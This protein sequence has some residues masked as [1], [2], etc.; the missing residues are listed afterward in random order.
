MSQSVE[1]ALSGD[2]GMEVASVRLQGSNYA[3]AA[4]SGELCGLL[5]SRDDVLGGFLDELDDFAG[6]LAFE[7]N[8][9]FASGQ[10]LRGYDTVTSTSYVTDAGVPL[11]QAGLAFTPVNG[12]FQILVYDKENETT[13]TTNVQVH[14]LGDDTDTTLQDLADAINRIDSLEASVTSDGRLTIT[15]QSADHQFAF[16]DDTSGLLA[17]IGI[18][19]LFTGS[20]AL[21]LGINEAM[22]SDP[23]KFAA[24][25]GGI[26]ADTR[27]AVA[28]AQ[29]AD[30]PIASHHDESI[31][32]VYDRLVAGMTQSS[33]AAQAAADGARAFQET[34]SG[35]KLAIS[36]VSV[37]EE[38][39]NLLTFQKAFQA[40]ARYI[41]VLNDIFD[42]LVNL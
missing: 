28:L 34:L 14:L 1:V 37:D 21:G 42:L 5:V 20:T 8:K 15:S 41:S 11:D 19:T 17:A 32:T 30:E 40:M 10:G 16:A 29:F 25:Q 6:T 27:N 7:F 39:I 23:A 31:T 3:L 13:Q 4:T 12:S 22:A 26:G 24:S 35:Q 9:I 18:N 2:R 38:A 36:G 33:T